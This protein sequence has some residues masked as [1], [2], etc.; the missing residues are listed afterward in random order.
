MKYTIKDLQK[1]FPND[2]VCLDYIFNRRFN[3]EYK[4]KCGKSSCFYKVNNR[5]TYA[6]SWCGHQISP[7][8][9]TVFHKSATS[10]T[11][12]FYA[13]FLFSTS[14]NG[15]SAKELERQLGVTY[16]TAWRMAKQ[17]RELMKNGSD[18]L[19]GTVEMDETYIGGKEKNKH[20]NK[21]VKNSQG[22]STKT[23][24]PV[25]GLVEREGNVI[26]EV[27]KNTNS[28][29]VNKL[30]EKNILE[31]SNIMTDEYRSYNK[32]GKTKYSH[33]RVKHSEGEYVNNEA[34][35]N[36]IEGFWSQLK[37]SINGT[38]HCVS[39]KY[40]QTYVDEFAWR[41]NYRQSSCPLFYRLLGNLCR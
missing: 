14:K 7:T 37:R 16:K 33:K 20:S 24:V 31:G 38:Y 27:V 41:Y 13:I 9:D 15:V 8:A 36:N 3:K 22:R 32:I 34:H 30:I 12:W 10:L 4:C 25:I 23:K 17:I 21:R 35:T 26:A 29:S 40:L 6:C 18:I 19:S 1:D 2:D 28:S 11:S 5:K 39:P